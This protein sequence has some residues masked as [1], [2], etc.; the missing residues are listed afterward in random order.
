MAHQQMLLYANQHHILE[1]LVALLFNASETGHGR[2]RSGGRAPA[3]P[4]FPQPTTPAAG[5]AMQFD[6]VAG[7]MANNAD[8]TNMPGKPLPG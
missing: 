1:Q 7:D 8:A 5:Q 3:P 2:C 4:G 6:T